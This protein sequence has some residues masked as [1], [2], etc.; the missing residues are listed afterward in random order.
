MIVDINT[1][2]TQNINTSNNR[3]HKVSGKLFDIEFR[4]IDEKKLEEIENKEDKDAQIIPIEHKK[5]KLARTKYKDYADESTLI[6][7]IAD[8]IFSR[9]MGLIMKKDSEFFE[10]D[11]EEKESII[12][13]TEKVY[14]KH[15]G[16][17]ILSPEMNLLWSIIMIYGMKIL[18]LK[19]DELINDSDN[20]KVIPNEKLNK[21]NNETEIKDNPKK[22]NVSK[23]NLNIKK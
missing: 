7:E 9:A 16:K 13:A 11:E 23:L 19:S 17:N 21:K 1:I 15:A 5:D 3:V 18:I 12:K 14:A 22:V 6:V 2:V 4:R 8:A 10:L 20:K